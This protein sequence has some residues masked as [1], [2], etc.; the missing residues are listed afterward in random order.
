MIE[1]GQESVLFETVGSILPFLLKYRNTGEMSLILD[2]LS[3]GVSFSFLTSWIFP[4][5]NSFSF[6][7]K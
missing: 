5:E 1:A 7:A 3:E 6:L 2:S 4:G